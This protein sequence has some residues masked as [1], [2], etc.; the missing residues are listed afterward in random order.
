M[1]DF[2]DREDGEAIDVDDVSAALAEVSH[3]L[4]P[5]DIVL[6]HTGRD[7]FYGREDYI[8]RG[9]GVTAAATQ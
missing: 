6:M 8:D 3:V 9:P 7:A 4:S 2:T 5:G 1:L